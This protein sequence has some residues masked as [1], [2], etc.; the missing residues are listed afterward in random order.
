MRGVGFSGR[1]SGFQSP[2]GAL[3]LI[4]ANGTLQGGSGGGATYTIS[5]SSQTA[6]SLLVLTDFNYPVSGVTGVATTAGP[7][8]TA[9]WA[10]I[11]AT[12]DAGL[13]ESI[14]EWYTTVTGPGALTVTVSAPSG[15][16]GYVQP[17]T[18]PF[19]GA[20]AVWTL[21]VHGH[22]DTTPA[23]TSVTFPSLTPT[24]PNEL[25]VAGFTNTTNN[26][27]LTTSGYVYNGPTL[28]Y[29]LNVSTVQAP[30]GTQTSS[31]FIA[32]AGLIRVT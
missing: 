12:S 25:Y 4:Q 1:T 20:A 13:D 24:Y 18:S 3:A 23:V 32:A 26:I 19:Y 21:D 16:F 15:G 9:A 8:T 28:I 17:F 22:V 30:T 5:V 6:G 2:G 11:D 14:D 7:G 10:K 27:T 31:I 29:N